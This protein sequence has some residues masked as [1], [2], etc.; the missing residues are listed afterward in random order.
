MNWAEP[1]D[2]LRNRL[3]GLKIFLYA[4]M[5]L[6]I[7]FDVWAPRHEAHFFGGHIPGFWSVFGFAGCILLI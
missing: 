4:L 2:F 5:G 6:A 3:K 1:M 7:V